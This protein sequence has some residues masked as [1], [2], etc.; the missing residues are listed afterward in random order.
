MSE[1][2][3]VDQNLIC[4]A[5][6]FGCKLAKYQCGRGKE[7]FDLVAD[8]EPLPERRGPMLT[9]SERAALGSDGR[10]P[11]ND[12]VMHAF[13]IITNVIQKRHADAGARKVVLT[14]ARTGSFMSLTLLP[15]RMTLSREEADTF[16]EEA[17]QADLVAVEND[18]RDVRIARLTDAGSEQAALWQ[19]ERDAE[20]AEFLSPLSDEEKETLEA[21]VRKLLVMPQ[22]PA[23]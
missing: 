1:T 19:A 4:P 22:R 17:Q 21:L 15:K 14:L 5:C 16:L 11:L 12:R 13:T 8:G 20:T 18:N 3:V 2:T 6:H 7:F 10:P 23:K 9:P